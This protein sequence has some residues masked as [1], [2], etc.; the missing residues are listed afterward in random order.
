[1]KKIIL[2]ILLSVGITYIVTAKEVKPDR[3]KLIAQNMYKQV[4]KTDVYVNLELVYISES[5]VFSSYDKT[6]YYKI[7]LFYVFNEVDEKGFVIVAGDDNAIPVLGYATKGSFDSTRLPI[8]FK[9]WLDNYKNQMHYIITHNVQA[10]KATK[11]KWDR[12]ERGQLLNDN[13]NATSVN[14]L[15]TVAWGQSPYV[16]DMCPYDENAGAQNGYHAV[17]GCPA[18]AMAQ[19]M[20]FWSY[21]T[22]G[23]GFHSYNHPT[24]GTLSANFGATTYDW[25]SM[26]NLVAGPNNAVATLM[27]HCGV[28]VE[29]QYGPTVSGSYVIM[30]GYPAEKT[31]EYAYKTYFGY[32][33]STI[34]GLRREN[35]SDNDW[36]QLMKNDLDAGRPIQYAGYGEGG[37]TFVCDGYDNND[38]FHMNWGWS[39]YYDGFFLLDDLSPGPGGTGSGAGHYNNGQQAVIGIQPPSG[40]G[41]SYNISLYDNVVVNPNPLWF[42]SS[43]T[44][45]TDVANF[46]SNAFNG[47]WAAVLFDKDYNF[48]DYIEVLSNY[49]LAAESHYQNGITFSTAG[50]ISALPGSYYV[51]VFYR[52]TGGD[53]VIVD[54]GNYANLI[55]FEIYYSNDIELYQDIV[56]DVGTKIEKNKPFTVTLDIANTGNSTFYGDFSVNLYNLDGSYAGTVQELTGGELAPGYFY[57][58]VQFATNGIDI[59]AGTYMLA[60]LHLKNGSSWELS[61]SSYYSNPIF[62]TVAEQQIQP[63][64]YENNDLEENAYALSLNFNGDNASTSTTGSNLHMGSDDDYYKIDLAPNYN[65]RISARAHDSYNS[66]DGNT[67]TGDVSWV[68]KANNAW[69][70]TYD[71]VM[72]GNITVNNGGSVY[73]KVSPYLAGVTGTYL[74]DINVSRTKDDGIEEVASN[75]SFSVYPNPVTDNLHIKIDKHTSVDHIEVINATGKTV[76]NIDHPSFE[77]EHYTIPV[78]YLK[79]GAYIILIK[80]HENSWKQKFIKSEKP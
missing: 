39:G 44:V 61:G 53:W 38:Y 2:F 72:T 43:F 30:D 64:M 36:K 79:P 11:Q 47:D 77:N 10:S 80:N 71:D 55:P 22:T 78:G 29:M 51:G 34:Q 42:G 46:G 66:G 1:M 75:Q 37:H 56:I 76:L 12:L 14:P 40:S 52:P 25:A 20:K 7:P 41:G 18:T 50:M 69:S 5:K 27:Y 21:P 15:V 74:L 54:N 35:Y 28:A 58:D 45:H 70:N 24:Y 13:K 32:N 60:L 48:V 68:Y 3:A 6:G 67:Y 65:Y 33:P 63:D 26:P 73:F 59:P 17:T 16:N 4:S 9:K 8:N 23:T 62:V 57:D 31:C 49:T 19:I